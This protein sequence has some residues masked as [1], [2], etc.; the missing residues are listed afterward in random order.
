MPQ[1]D[2]GVFMPQLI[3]LAI[4]FV[5][6]YV[7]MARVALPRIGQVLE[8]RQDR[9]AHDLEGAASFKTDAEAVLAEYETAMANARSRAQTVLAEAAEQRAGE[10]TGRQAQLDE[11]LAGRLKEAEARIAKAKQAALK[12][13]ETVA[14]DIARAATEKLIGEAVDDAAVSAALASTDQQGS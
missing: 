13:L 5:I 9:I 8:A 11:R 10:A 2:P 6:L 1:L 7:V 4:T 14:G 3:W 12:N